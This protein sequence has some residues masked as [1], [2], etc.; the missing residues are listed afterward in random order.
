MQT[1]SINF[2]P[3]DKNRDKTGVPLQLGQEH[4]SNN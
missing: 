4:L 2:T 3:P 1:N